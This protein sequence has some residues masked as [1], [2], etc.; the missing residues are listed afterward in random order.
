MTY[1]D[2]YTNELHSVCD[3]IRLM[4]YD[5]GYLQESRQTEI[6]FVNQWDVYRCRPMQWALTFP[7]IPTKWVDE[8]CSRLCD[9]EFGRSSSDDECVMSRK[10][11]FLNAPATCCV[12]SAMSEMALEL[13]L[14]EQAVC[15]RLDW[16]I[17]V[18]VVWSAKRHV[19]TSVHQAQTRVIN[20]RVLSRA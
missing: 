4:E 14:D 18:F 2:E 9:K 10:I 5:P 6:D 20:I 12:A 15:S 16:R 17:G 11:M 13:Q 1:S 3:S 7:V 8:R 19:A